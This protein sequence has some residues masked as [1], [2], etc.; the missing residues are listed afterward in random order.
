MKKN[1]TFVLLLI[2]CGETSLIAQKYQPKYLRE[3]NKAFK[4][5]T[6]RTTENGWITFKKEAKVNP[7]TFFKD[8]ASI[9]GLERDYDFK[10]TREQKDEKGRLHQRFQLYY[11]NIVV[12]GV[13]FLLHTF[14]DGTLQT[15]HGRIVEGINTDVS[16]PMT[17][18]AALLLAL[19]NKKLTLDDFKGENSKLPE[20]TLL[21]AGLD[22][23]AMKTSF[24][25]AYAFNVYGKSTFDAHKV[26]VDAV[27]GEIVKRTSLIHQCFKQHSNPTPSEPL[28]TT[29]APPAAATASLV[30][31]SLTPRYNRYG[32]TRNF[33]TETNPNNAAQF[34]LS[35]NNG[36]LITRIAP[37]PLPNV[38]LL[39]TFN[40]QPEVTN[41]TTVWGM[42]SQNSSTTHW[43]AWHMY[44][45]LN[46]PP[47]NRNGIDGNGFIARI[48][49]NCINRVPDNN[50][51]V[52]GWSEKPENVM[53]I[54]FGRTDGLLDMNRPL[55]TIDI[56][57]HELMHGYTNH[58]AGL[59]Y[60]GESGAI[61]ESISDIFGTVIE[62]NILGNL[63]WTLGE[64]AFL[65]RNMANPLISADAAQPDRYQ[66]TNWYT[67]SPP[68][69]RS[70]DACG[71]H[72]NSG[73]MN[74]WF[75]TLCTG[76][77][78]Y[79]NNVQAIEFDNATRIVFRALNFYL[80]STPIMQMP[81]KLPSWRREI[82]TALALL[83]R[84]KLPT[85]GRRVQ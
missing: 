3:D 20:G 7:N 23:E 47:Y 12:E 15:V 83:R 32:Q 39:T 36:V 76:Q 72:I 45:Y 68:C 61:N 85:L 46:A 48:L 65:I 41:P 33:D 56:V 29:A 40:A 82:C 10:P 52:A 13:E 16:K 24:R 17:E 73:V 53:V 58:M 51:P 55:A 70:N 81:A 30:L 71:V 18:R 25:L 26:Y 69:N 84:Y 49:T 34:R 60:A 75:H 44:N 22:N 50:F 6:E 9:L 21:L 31:S 1:L 4:S 8:Y 59:V 62:R 14:E 35:S 67:I 77:S 43:I 2:I 78:P 38:P 63:N 66:G 28:E 42:N 57:S 64:D 37:N 19:A 80:N 54:G 27:S 5:L 79:A 74:K 11:K